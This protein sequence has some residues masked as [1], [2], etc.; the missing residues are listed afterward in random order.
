VPTYTSTS[1]SASAASPGPG[2]SISVNCAIATVRCEQFARSS[3]EAAS[4]IGKIDDRAPRLRRGT[5]PLLRSIEQGQFLGLERRN[6][7]EQLSPS[8]EC[9]DERISQSTVA[10]RRH[11]DGRCPSDDK[12]RSVIQRTGPCET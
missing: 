3:V 2:F 4:G 10:A 6:V 1:I 12:S 11:V 8:R 7:N 9:R 5:R